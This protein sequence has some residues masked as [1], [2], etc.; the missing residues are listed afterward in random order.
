MV[1]MTDI[2]DWSDILFFS[3]LGAV[4]PYIAVAAGEWASRHFRR[5]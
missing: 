2:G 4:F 3:A 5:P 1:A